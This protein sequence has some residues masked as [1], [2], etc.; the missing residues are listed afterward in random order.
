MKKSSPRADV[1]I[2]G[3]GAGGGVV[4]KE[5]A[6]KG[7]N[8]VVLE[9]GRRYDPLRDYTSARSDW[10]TADWGSDKFKVAALNKVT[11]GIKG[12]HRPIEVY[13]V[14]GGTLRYFAYALRMRP[15][16]FHIYSS[17]GVGVDWPITY[18][19]LVPYYRKVELELGVSGEAGDPWTPNV[20]PYLNPPF[21]YSYAN[22]I[23]KRGCDRLGIK[24]WPT[25]MARL[26]RPFDGRPMCVQC[27]HCDGGCMSGAKSSIDVTYISK[28]EATGKMV[29]RPECIATRIGISPQGK[30]KS[31]LYFDKNGIEHEQEADVIVVSAGIIQSPRLLLNSTSKLFPDGLANSNG[32]VGK[33]FMQHFNIRADAIFPDRIDSYRGFFGGASSQDFAKSSSTNSFSRGWNTALISGIRAPIELALTSSAWGTQL[34][35]YMRNNFGHSAG[36]HMNAEQIPDKRNYMELDPEMRD[37]YGM[38]VPRINFSLQENDKLMLKAMKKKL[39]EI[40]SASGALKINYGEIKPG[41]SAHNF[42]GCRMGNDS[43]RAVLNSFCQ[44]HE[45]P[46]LFVVDSSCFVTTGTANPTLTIHAIAVRSSEYIAAQGKKRNL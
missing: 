17:D 35:D 20:E 44:S 23:I 30:A 15:D 24:L 36:I 42:G 18:K 45:V 39:K 40:L 12:T 29:L 14:G 9:A 31:V 27:G 16:D 25:P 5:L 2:I 34:K 3:S 19:D 13:G 6:E 28:A 4:A 26:S 37:D 11:L 33:Y 21:P 7:I 38:P 1:C 22:K 41:S 10:A 8:V 43:N 32:L 46:N